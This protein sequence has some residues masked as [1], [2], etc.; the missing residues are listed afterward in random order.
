MSCRAQQQRQASKRY[1]K[2]KKA[3]IEQLEI[4]LKAL[5]DEKFQI[6]L[7]H[8]QT[9]EMVNKLKQ[10]NASLRKNHHQD[11]EIVIRK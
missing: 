8:K 4:K 9:I 3:L 10:E 11:S 1:R 5:T 2:K 7:E 6:E